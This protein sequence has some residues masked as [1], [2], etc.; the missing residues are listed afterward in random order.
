MKAMAPS[1]VAGISALSLARWQFGITTV[2]HFLFVP[3]SIGLAFLVALLQTAA[4]RTKDARYERLARW[5][6]HLFLVNFAIGVVTG[7]VL[8]F[9]FGMAWSQYSGFVGN[10]FGP[11]L[12]IE[13]LLAFFME[14]TFLGVWIFGRDRVSRRVHLACIWMVSL[15]T[16]LSAAFILAANAWMQHPVGFKID[17]KTGQAVMTDFWAVIANSTFIGEYLHVVFAALLTGAMF[18]LGISAW[19]MRKENQRALHALSARIAIVVAV[20]A[21]LGTIWMGDS[22][23]KL[24]TKQQP[25]KMAAAEALYNSEQG[26]SFSLITI[27]DLTG[28][29]V[30]QVRLP[31]LLSLLATNTWNGN[32][33]G[34]NQVQAAEVREYGPGNY[35]PVLWITYWSF[36]IMVGLGFLMLG[37]A[38][39]GLWLMRRRRLEE[40]PRYLRIAFW[41]LAAPFVANSTGWV[42][43]EMGRQPWVVYGLLTTAK[44]VSHV[45]AVTVGISLVAFT[46][47]YTFLAIVEIGLIVR[48]AHAGRR[49]GAA[50]A[51]R[52]RQRGGDHLGA[53]GATG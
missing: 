35:K 28:Q 32:V 16:L 3:L 37:V 4:Y 27:G 31:H 6:G 2:F 8:E 5:W 11:P 26:A 51:E 24:M 38:F 12:A 39:Y 34:I 43:T 36:R 18:M 19:H 45:S 13:G 47:V 25:M 46:V 20:F 23:A 44:A 33:E 21:V 10:I 53:A 52:G 29:P 49:R 17:A 7:I 41:S 40:A 50:A 1:L 30:F 48:L 9:Q 15:G 14:S 42:F 22:Q